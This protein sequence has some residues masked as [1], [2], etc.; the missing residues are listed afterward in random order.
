M[1]KFVI[2][3]IFALLTLL[4]CDLRKVE[5]SE[6]VGKYLAN[7]EEGVDS[8]ILEET[9]IFRLYFHPYNDSLSYEDTGKWSVWDEKYGQSILFEDVGISY[10]L[11]PLNYPCHTLLEGFG[12]RAVALPIQ[13]YNDKADI[14]IVI[15]SDCGKYYRKQ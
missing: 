11:E 4:H 9:G 5:R 13:A 7:H 6:M 3:S 1:K 12:K 15:N 14:V 10:Y 2:V 8:L